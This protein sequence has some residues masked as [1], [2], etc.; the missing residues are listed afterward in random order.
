MSLCVLYQLQDMLDRYKEKIQVA[1]Q[2]L[3]LNFEVSVFEVPALQ[4]G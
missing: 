2:K 3:M 1:E 4:H